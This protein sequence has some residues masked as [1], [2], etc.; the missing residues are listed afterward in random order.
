MAQK[1]EGLVILYTGAGKGKTSAALGLIMRAVAAK[2]RVALL[3]FIKAWQTGEHRILKERFPEVSVLQFGLGFVGIMGDKRDF[4]E[5]KKAAEAGLKKAE[6]IIG[7]GKFDVVILDEICGSI[8]SGLIELAPVLRLVKE[9]PRELFLVLTGR[10]APE[11]LV[12][13]ADLATEMKKLK[14]PFDKGIL[15]IQGIDF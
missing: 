8:K 2:K 5:H 3:Q 11:E 1:K 6:E 14:H 9:K 4:S 15:A 12:D 7:S 13:A 10:E